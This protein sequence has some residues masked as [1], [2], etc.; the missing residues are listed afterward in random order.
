MEFGI[1]LVPASIHLQVDA[2]I[3]GLSE[4]YCC[5]REAAIG[6]GINLLANRLLGVHPSQS[7]L[8]TQLAADIEGC[9]VSASNPP[10]LKHRPWTDTVSQNQ[11][12]TLFKYTKLQECYDEYQFL[13]L[14]TEQQMC[15]EDAADIVALK[16]FS[17]DAGLHDRYMSAAK[18]EFSKVLKRVI[19][20]IKYQGNRGPEEE[21]CLT[22]LKTK[23]GPS[24]HPNTKLYYS[25]GYCGTP[26]AVQIVDGRVVSVAEFKSSRLDDAFL[27]S[28]VF[29]PAK[30]QLEF[31]MKAARVCKGYVVL[32]LST[33]RDQQPDQTQT[34][35][36]E[37]SSGTVDNKK[38]HQRE[39]MQQRFLQDL[40]TKT[41]EQLPKVLT[42]LLGQISGGCLTET[43]GASKAIQMYSEDEGDSPNVMRLN[44]RKATK[45]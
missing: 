30:I 38:L 6:R 26:D 9:S 41:E 29:N 5:S 24:F 43:G 2:L 19:D 42:R 17:F 33:A 12:Q 22:A 27:D 31:C 10:S 25:E 37:M 32:H 15:T 16:L 13:P 40:M 18:Y 1:D 20:S 3:A 14:N 11:A 21:V 23:F 39:Q 44:K 4:H 34:R 45:L 8:N 35:I 7:K 28:H 36:L